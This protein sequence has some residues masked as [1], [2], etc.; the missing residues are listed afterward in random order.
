MCR[1]ADTQSIG[2]T[3][4]FFDQ[5]AEIDH[6]LLLMVIGLGFSKPGIKAQAG[7][8]SLFTV[9]VLTGSGLSLIA[10]DINGI[11][12][13]EEIKALL[14]AA[15]GVGM[16]GLS[17]TENNVY[18]RRFCLV[19]WPQSCLRHVARYIRYQFYAWLCNI[20]HRVN[21]YR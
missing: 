15:V 20:N 21:T 9:L 3:S 2:F 14:I 4:G 8:L 19:P 12:N 13:V 10:F 17:A 5:L 16:Q 11:Q 7:L 1:W 6:I 18:H